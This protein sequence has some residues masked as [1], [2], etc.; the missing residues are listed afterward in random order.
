MFYP[1]P[2]VF[3]RNFLVSSLLKTPFVIRNLGAFFC[4]QP[5]KKTGLSAPIFWLR[6]KDF[7]C[8]PW[9]TQGLFQLLNRLVNSI[10]LSG[11]PV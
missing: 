8:N 10:P 5:G 1:S 4:P 9:R 3:S 6:Q 11:N 2:A 7:R